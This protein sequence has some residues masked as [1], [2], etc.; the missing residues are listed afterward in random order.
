VGVSFAAAMAGRLEAP[1]R[2]AVAAQGGTGIE[3]WLPAEAF[4]ATAE[5]ARMRKLA[6]DAQVQAAAEADEADFRPFGEHRLARWGLGRAGPGRLF[7]ERVRPLGEL[8]VVGVVWYQGESNATSPE[9]G[10]AYAGWLRQLIGAY[11]ELWGDAALPFVIVQLPEYDP[12]DA[13]Q[14]AGWEAVREAQA[15]VAREMEAVA[16][17]DIYELG[18]RGDIHPARKQAVGERAAAAALRLR[19]EKASGERG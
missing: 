4:P 7:E 6:G 2:I 9:Q 18:E 8:P 13:E 11:R 19:G 10:R 1:V 3:A 17:V 12:G 16:L 5:G 14:R 15:R